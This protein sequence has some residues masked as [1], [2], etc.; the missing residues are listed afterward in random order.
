MSIWFFSVMN[1][2]NEA[3]K[4]I[5]QKKKILC[6]LEYFLRID[7]QK[8]HYSNKEEEYLNSYFYLA[9]LSHMFTY[10]WKTLPLALKFHFVMSL[11]VKV[12]KIPINEEKGHCRIGK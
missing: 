8:W 11:N 1:N 5:L 3:T 9:I 7:S 6:I 2:V 12:G 4:N 10:M